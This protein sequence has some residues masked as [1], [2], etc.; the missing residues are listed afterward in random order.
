[1]M[2]GVGWRSESLGEMYPSELRVKISSVAER[3]TAEQ[4]EASEEFG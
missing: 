4:A 2:P 1:M 3:R